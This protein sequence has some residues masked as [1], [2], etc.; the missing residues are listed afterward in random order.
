VPEVVFPFSG[1]ARPIVESHTNSRV[2]PTA[3][4]GIEIDPLYVDTAIRR[5][6]SITGY[7]ARHI[8]GKTFG[9]IRAERIT[10]P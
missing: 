2:K 9:E 8:C 7:Q 4:S 6:E 3:V 5:W 10:V 1:A